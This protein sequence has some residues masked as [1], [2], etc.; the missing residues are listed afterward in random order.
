MTRTIRIWFT[1]CLGL[2]GCDDGAAPMVATWATSMSQSGGPIRDETVRQVARISLG[3]EVLRVR[4][5]NAFGSEPTR[6][7]SATIGL[8]AGGAAVEPGTMQALTFDGSR[9]ADIPAGGELSSDHVDLTVPD[10]GTLVIS[11]YLESDSGTVS[12]HTQAHQTTYRVAGDQTDAL[13][14]AAA[15]TETEV[16]WLSGVD[17]RASDAPMT[18]VTLGDSI[19]AGAGSDIDGHTRYP[20]LLATELAARG[21]RAAVPN[22][23]IGGNRLLNDGPLGL[24]GGP[25]A[26]SRLS[27]DVLAQP[28]ATHVLLLEGVNDLGIGALFG[29]VVTA[30]EIIGAYEE[31]ITRAHE[32]GL[33]VIVGTILPFRGTDVPEYWS[34][35]NEIK[36]DTLNTWIR[37]TDMHDGFIDFDAAM[38]DPAEPMQMPAA[39]HSGDSLH[40]NSAGYARM[41]EAAADFFAP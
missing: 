2:L 18:I 22:A 10:G 36:R 13:D 31:I 1:L 12:R 15:D 14:L 37:T 34:P 39:L 16:Y 6:I 27:R 32:R 33:V 28:G 17:V 38:Q 4:L 41:A 24:I 21:V 3:G 9:S 19:T 40:P 11:L 20:D 5:S 23:G 26:L 30:E 35:E 7:G 8:S 29:P 25:S